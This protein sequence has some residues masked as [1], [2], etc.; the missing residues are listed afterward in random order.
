[1]ATTPAK[2]LPRKHRCS[3]ADV[4]RAFADVGREKKRPKTKRTVSR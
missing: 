1:M 3:V 4:M 2:K